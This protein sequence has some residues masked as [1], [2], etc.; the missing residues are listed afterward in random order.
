VLDALTGKRPYKEAFS[1]G[2]A[3]D[4]IADGGIKLHKPKISSKKYLQ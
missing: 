2:K 3:L 4:I 1:F